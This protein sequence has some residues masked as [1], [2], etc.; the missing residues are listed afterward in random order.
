MVATDVGA[1]L[2]TGHFMYEQK[3]NRRFFTSQGLGEMGFG[4]PGALGAHFSDMSKQIVCL[5]G[6]SLLR[7]TEMILICLMNS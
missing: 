5:N 1:A 3:G 4:L 6:K 2:L 7:N